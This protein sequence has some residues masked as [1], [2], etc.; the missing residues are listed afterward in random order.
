[1]S[2]SG[3]CAPGPLTFA[4]MIVGSWYGAKGGLKVA[5]G[6]MIF[7]APYVLLLLMMF[8]SVKYFF[9]LFITKLV[10]A[11]LACIF[12]L[13]FSYVGYIS[14]RDMVK[15][16]DTD[17]TNLIDKKFI[18]YITKPI[19]VGILMT[20]LNPWFLIWWVTIGGIIL[21]KALQLGI[22]EAFLLVI[23]AHVWIDYAWLGAMAYLAGKGKKILGRKYGYVLQALSIILA[24]FGILLIVKLVY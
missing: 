13:Y 14:G 20:G 17:I 9:E 2:V 18:K 3:A 21:V 11:I 5:V 1:M 7:E 8:N 12:I 4:A 19:I 24:I 10:L 16:G 15:S 6:H 23:F 22:L